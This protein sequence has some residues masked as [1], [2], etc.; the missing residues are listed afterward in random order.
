MTTTQST[1]VRKP[2][3][4]IWMYGGLL[5]LVVAGILYVLFA[6]SSNSPSSDRTPLGGAALSLI[7]RTLQ[8]STSGPAFGL[9]A[10][11][12]AFLL[13]ALHALTPG[14]N[15]TLVGAYLV[16]A[17][18]RLRHAFLVGAAT[19]L[20]HTASALV[21]GVL[22]LSTAGQIATSQYLRWVGLPTGLLTVGLGLWLLRRHFAAVASHTDAHDHGHDHD[23][24]HQ[25]GYGHLHHGR[26]GVTLGGLLVLG[27]MHGLIPTFDALAVIL[28][29]LNVQKLAL[30]IGIMAAYSLG[31]G[32]VL[33][34]VGVLFVRAQGVL[35]DHPRFERLSRWSPVVAGLVVVVLG[36]WL[37]MR[38]LLSLSPL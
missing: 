36:L 24:D 27:L 18:G 11:A 32:S 37:A 7:Q 15:K 29:A 8:T 1:Q 3:R 30:G 19:A 9:V 20:S 35:G 38:T 21:V 22:T 23:H 12:A 4:L 10:L 33:T 31:I 16:S 2:G 28:V 14:H 25:H 5:A 26:V 6:Y 17:G 13:G 34:A